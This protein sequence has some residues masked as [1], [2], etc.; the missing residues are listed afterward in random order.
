M[1]S[2]DRGRTWTSIAGDLPA[3]HDVWAVIQDHENGDLLF[4]GTEFGV[5]VTFDGG[6]DWTQLEGG[7]PPAQIR[8]M[9]VQKRENDLVLGTFGR[10]FYVLDDYSA[11]REIDA[12]ALSADARL[13]PLRHVYSFN[14]TGSAPAGSASIASLSGNFTTPNPPSG[15]VFT[16]HVNADP[17][18]EETLV[19]IVRDGGGEQ[20]REMELD[21]SRGLRR[22]TWDLRADPPEPDPDQAEAAGGRGGGGFAGGGRGGRG[23]LVDPGRYVASIGWKV[24]DDIVEVGPSHSFHV[25]RAEW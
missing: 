17:E 1:K 11:L 7:L 2:T 23:T 20:V 15:A 21:S 3:R 10:G 24:G 18:E 8:D 4:A 12:E 13:F 22:V 25:I 19:L 9:V 16:Y 14:T 5:F 6:N